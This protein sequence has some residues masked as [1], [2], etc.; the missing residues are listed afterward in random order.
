[1]EV[2]EERPRPAQ[3]Q[4]AAEPGKPKALRGRESIRPARRSEQPPDEEDRADSQ[5]QTGSS[6]EDR[7]DRGQLPFVDLKVRR[8][9]PLNLRHPEILGSIAG[10]AEAALI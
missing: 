3:E 10:R 4:Q 1:G 2:I 9:R 6:M 7:E 5:R 8:Q